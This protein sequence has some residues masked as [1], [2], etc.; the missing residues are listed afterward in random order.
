[1]IPPVADPRDVAA[2]LT[3]VDRVVLLFDFDGTLSPI[4]SRPDDASLV[5]GAAAVIKR[6]AATVPVAISSGRHLDD[7]IE[8]IGADLPV[9]LIAGH[10]STVRQ[11]DG[12]TVDLIDTA[13][14]SAA[15]DAVVADLQALVADREGWLIE[16]KPTSVAAHYRRA[17]DAV[18]AAVLPEVRTTMRHHAVRPPGF[19]ILDGKQVIELRPRTTDK[20]RALTHLMRQFPARRPIAIGDD[21][22][23]E[24]AFTAARDAG[25]IGIIVGAA[26]HP[27]AA[28]WRL[29]DPAAV[30]AMLEL[31]A[32]RW[33]PARG[34][35]PRP[36]ASE[37]PVVTTEPE[38]TRHE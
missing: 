27:T 24:D 1:M 18:T 20:G 5:E 30:I 23:D 2:A 9:I 22:T 32:D 7:L 10:G 6:L 19:E 8:R 31:L 11:R 4:A 38:R 35:Q 36:A 12:A 17:D 34:D 16:R 15:L 26:T 3:A 21:V 13:P 14:L 33:S 37:H 28:H 25:G 29:E